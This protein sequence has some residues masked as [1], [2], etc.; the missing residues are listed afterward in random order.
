MENKSNYTQEQVIQILK[1]FVKTADF[2]DFTKEYGI[3]G[4]TELDKMD[5]TKHKNNKEN[6]NKL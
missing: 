5:R 4:W 3:A 2:I 6:G 1:H